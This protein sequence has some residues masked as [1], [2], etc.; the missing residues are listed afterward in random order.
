V[1]VVISNRFCGPPT[2]ANGGWV[3]GLLAGR[4]GDG[5]AEVRLSAPPPLETELTLDVAD[6]TATL[7]DGPT[8]LATARAATLDLVVPAAIGMDEARAASAAAPADDDHPFRTCFGCGPMREP[9]DALRHRCGPVAGR[10]G[11]VACPMTTD[12]ALPHDADGALL[13]E[14]IWAA[15]DCPSAAAVVP[16]GSAPHVLGTMAARIDRPVLAGVPH[17]CI[18]WPLSIDGRKR[19]GASAI[20]DA[21]GRVCAVARALWIA[22]DPGPV[23]G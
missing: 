14:V 6:G 7:H 5:A 11:L 21:D 3:A 8:L 18:A 2:S 1:R 13:G 4:L 20:L 9:G 10:D 16:P 19:H 15:L 12:P 22:L 23:L 17:V